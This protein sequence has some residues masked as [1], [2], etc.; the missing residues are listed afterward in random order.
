MKL[1][2]ARSSNRAKE[3]GVRKV[4]GSLR[5][6]LICQFLTDS[7]LLTAGSF[8]LAVVIAWSVLP[9]FNELAL[10]QLSLPFASQ[11][12]SKIAGLITSLSRRNPAV[13]R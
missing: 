9:T 7:V 11:G 10:K 2:T 6:H 1:S 12:C 13:S 4:M 8:L 3:V 5:S